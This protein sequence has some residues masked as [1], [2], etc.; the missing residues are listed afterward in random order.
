MAP[1]PHALVPVAGVRFALDPE[2][3]AG[4]VSWLRSL[5]GG[6]ADSSGGG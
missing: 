2:P 6:G 5:L 1:Q 3:A 4:V